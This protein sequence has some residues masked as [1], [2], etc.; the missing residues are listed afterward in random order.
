MSHVTNLVLLGSFEDWAP[1]ARLYYLL[2]ETTGSQ[3]PLEFSELD[4]G[5]AHG[6]KEFEGSVLA[7]A[8][9]GVLNNDVVEAFQVQPWNFPDQVVLVAQAEDEAAQVYRPSSPSTSLR[10]GCF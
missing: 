1:V 7:L 6:N 9:N 4:L 8:F 10:N 2:T 3:V 5:P